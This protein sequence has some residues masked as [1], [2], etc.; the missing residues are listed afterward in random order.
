MKVIHSRMMKCYN[1]KYKTPSKMYGMIIVHDKYKQIERMNKLYATSN[2]NKYM[3]A[4]MYIKKSIY[5][6][7]QQTESE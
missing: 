7:N 4:V 5:N 3:I 2:N 1:N 6:L